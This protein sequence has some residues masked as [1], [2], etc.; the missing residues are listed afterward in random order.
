MAVLRAERT[1][2][3]E[4]QIAMHQIMRAIASSPVDAQRV[5]DD[6]SEATARLGGTD[7][8]L[9]HRVDGDAI[10]GLPILGLSQ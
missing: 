7:R 3:V 6:I 2:A 4:Q 5:L 1:E 9:I 8:A 10:W